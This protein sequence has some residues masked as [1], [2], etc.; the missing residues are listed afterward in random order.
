[1]N[2]LHFIHKVRQ[3]LNRGLHELPST[4][5]DRL[6]AARQHALA[7]QKIAAHQSVLAAAGS[8]I[9]F[10]LDNLKLKQSLMALALL[11]GVASYSVWL[12]DQQVSEM[13]AIDSALLADDLPVSA[14]TDKGFEAWLKNSSAQ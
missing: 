2:E 13:E 5:L 7:H 11:L 8:F 4:T 1:M 10:H 3:Q 9:S 12:A 6:A 14:L